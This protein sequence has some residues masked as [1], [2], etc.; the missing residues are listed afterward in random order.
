MSQVELKNKLGSAVEAIQSGSKNSVATFSADTHLVKGVLTNA[1]IRNFSF[2]IDEPH[3]LGG[4][5]SAPNPVE[6][7]LASLGA[8]QEILYSAYASFLGIELENVQV[9]VKGT[10]DLKGLF[11]LD[12]TIRPGFQ[13]VEYETIITSSTDENKLFELAAIVENHCP[14]L[15]IIANKTEV[16]G[17]LKIV[18]K[19]KAA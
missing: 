17:Q 11:G 19:Q 9:K 3:E 14:V 18:N 16:S 13:K 6:Y 15:D 1:R 10:L 8:C 4:S 2:N 7:V 5:D 12:K